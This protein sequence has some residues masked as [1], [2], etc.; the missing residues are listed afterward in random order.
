MSWDNKYCWPFN[1]NL[2]NSQNWNCNSQ[3]IGHHWEVFIQF[4]AFSWFVSNTKK[5]LQQ[6]LLFGTYQL[7]CVR[8][9]SSDFTKNLTSSLSHILDHDFI[10]QS[11]SWELVAILKDVRKSTCRTSLQDKPTVTA[12]KLYTWT[13]IFFKTI[14]FDS[15]SFL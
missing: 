15:G 9:K 7:L 6:W 10:A 12:Q 13:Y 4:L 14:Q 1:T 3:S 5:H 11:Q 8:E 2:K